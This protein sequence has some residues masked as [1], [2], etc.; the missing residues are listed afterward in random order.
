[1]QF[2]QWDSGDLN[3]SWWKHLEN[4]IPE[5]ASMGF[6]HVWIPPPNKAMSSSGRGY[7]AYDLWDLGEFQQGGGLATRWG[8]KQELLDA[9]A[10]AQKFGISIIMDAVLNHKLGGDRTEVVKAI[11]VEEENRLVES[12]P[13]IEI[14]WWTA[15]DFPGRNNQVRVDRDLRSQRDRIYKFCGE[16]HKGWS[17]K[18]DTERGNYDYLLGM[19][20]DH[21]HPDTRQDLIKWGSWVLETTGASGFRL[22]AIKHI[23]SDFTT[24]FLRQVRRTRRGAEMFAVGEY[25]NGSA[26]TLEHQ[27]KVYKK[28]ISLFDVALHYQFHHASKYGSSYDLRGILHESLVRRKPEFAVTFVDNH[29][30]QPGQS[31]ESWIDPTFK[32]QA[33]ALILLRPNGLPCVF[34]GDL[35]PNQS[36]YDPSVAS[37]LRKLIRARQSYAFGPI[38]DY[39]T[40]SPNCIGF[41]R[42]GKAKTRDTDCAVVISNGDPAGDEFIIS[43]NVGTARAGLVYRDIFGLSGDVTI[44]RDGWGSFRGPASGVAV[45]TTHIVEHASRGRSLG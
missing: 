33:Y 26:E 17:L 29:D 41:V 3:I 5:L 2:F 10:T 21:S 44:S 23:D 28:Q 30:T 14:E 27:I 6:T 32:L 1:L 12:G 37:G 25:W 36:L 8:N 4:E 38:R 18:V 39:T 13:P 9:C 42:M 45:W 31:L 40:D 7:D 20:I 43:M 11:P 24:E 35:Y 15:F 22:D 34:Y 16:G 19:S